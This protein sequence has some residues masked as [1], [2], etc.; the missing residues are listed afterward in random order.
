[1]HFI[2]LILGQNSQA[3]PYIT[4]TMVGQE[5]YELET[6]TTPSKHSVRKIKWAGKCEMCGSRY[7]MS[8][9][10]DLTGTP[11]V[12]IPC[13]YLFK[14]N[15]IKNFKYLIYLLISWIHCYKLVIYFAIPSCSKG[16]YKT[17]CNLLCRPSC[18]WTHRDPPP[19]LLSTEVKGM[20]HYAIESLCGLVPA[21][22]LAESPAF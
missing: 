4:H 7:S 21:T 13:S 12:K 18:P 17:M 1:M 20:C 2:F 15:Y 3:S 19:L 9:S 14:T 22:F 5:G 6:W 16:K 8:A 10:L 11:R